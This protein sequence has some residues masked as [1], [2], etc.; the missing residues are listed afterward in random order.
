VKDWTMI[1]ALIALI[2]GTGLVAALPKPQ[3]ARVAAKRK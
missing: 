3:P 1:S 2:L